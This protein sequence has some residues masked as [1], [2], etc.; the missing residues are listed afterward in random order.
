MKT[1]SEPDSTLIKEAAAD[2]RYLLSRGY[3]RRESL[4]LVGNRYQLDH[5]ARQVLH[6]GVFAPDAAQT[7]RAKLRLLRDL[8]GQPLGVDGHNVLITLECAIQ[9][10][11]LV[12]ADDGFIRDVG[13]VSKTFRASPET[14]QALA[15]LADYLVQQQAGPVSVFYDAPLSLSGELAHHTRELWAA[16]GLTVT[17]AAVPVPERELLAFS[18]PIASSD[19]HLIDARKE[20]VDLAGEIIRQEAAG[21]GQFRILT[22]P[23]SPGK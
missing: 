15:L 21:G 2:F 9:K 11:P 20:I 10:L 7:R 3:P 14:E 8:A 16:R 23:L 1:I 18:G 19:T 17:A 12:A 5:T 6:R 4:A 22:F 13:Q